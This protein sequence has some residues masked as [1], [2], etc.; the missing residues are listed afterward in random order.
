MYT[1]I[2][3]QAQTQQTQTHTLCDTQTNIQGRVQEWR[4]SE[5]E[6]MCALIDLHSVVE[7]INEDYP[8]YQYNTAVEYEYEYMPFPIYISIDYREWH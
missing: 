7:P 1:R 5:R 6:R 4:E 8:Q 2:N 3:K